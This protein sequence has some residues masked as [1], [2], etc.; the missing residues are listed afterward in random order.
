MNELLTQSGLLFSY[1]WPLLN[2]FIL[3][4][5]TIRTTALR[6]APW[7]ALPALLSAIFIDTGNATSALQRLLFASEI[8]LDETAKLFLLFTSILWLLAGIYAQSYIDREKQQRFYLYFLL[9]LAGNIR[10]LVAE[11]LF[12]F[13]FGYALMSFAAYGLVVFANTAAA[14]RAGRIYIVLIVLSEILV[15]SALVLASQATG[16]TTFTAVREGLA[17]SDIVHLVVGLSL[18][19]FGIKAG[20]LGL[21]TWLPLAHSQ[22]PAPASAVLSGAMI[23]VGVLGWLRILPLGAVALPEW[24]LAVLVLGLSAAFYAVA[25]GLTQQAPKTLLAYS[26]ISQMGILT[27]MLGMA[28]LAPETWHLLLPVMIFFALQHGLNKSALFLG[29]GLVNNH[30]RL[31]HWRFWFILAVPALALAG[32]PWTSG[33]LAKSL[34]KEPIYRLPGILPEVLPLVLFFTS[35]ATALLLARFLFIVQPKKVCDTSPP[36]LGLVIPWATTLILAQ[37]L[38]WVLIPTA[39]ELNPGKILNSAVP[40]LLTLLIV[41]PL[42]YWPIRFNLPVIAAGDIGVTFERAIINGIH[43]L[44]HSVNRLK[45]FNLHA[46]RTGARRPQ[47]EVDKLLAAIEARLTQWQVAVGVGMVLGFYIFWYTAA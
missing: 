34:L 10:A 33:M 20:I 26:S 42:L 37:V 24:G 45:Q 39:P 16:S 46:L 9:A 15:F 43:Y 47:E 32:S 6:L 5:P 31:S 2:A 38:P 25:I 30:H 36:G 11:D 4:V 3:A 29:A 22:A 27:A 23:K 19:G 12:G 14:F 1:F 41:A 40:I 7:A 18:A 35:L 13:Y 44:R 28:M 8:G 21:H 17:D